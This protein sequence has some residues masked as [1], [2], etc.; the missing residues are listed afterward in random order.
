[1]KLLKH[2]AE[3]PNVVALK[4]DAGDT[5]CHDALW[6]AGAAGL[7]ATTENMDYNFNVLRFGAP[8]ITCFPDGTIFIAFWC[9]EDCVSNIR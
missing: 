6:G 1:M 3:I 2:L 7:T 4:E 5:W 9:V 8:C